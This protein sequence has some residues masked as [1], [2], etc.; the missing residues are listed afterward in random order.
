MIWSCT[1]CL[2]HLHFCL[3]FSLPGN[4]TSD[5][6]EPTP[7]IIEWIPDILPKSRIGELRIKLEYGHQRN[8]QIEHRMW[9][10]QELPIQAIT[11]QEISWEGRGPGGP[12]LDT[13]RHVGDCFSPLKDSFS[14]FVCL[15]D[16]LCGCVCVCVC[17]HACQ[18][19]QQIGARCIGLVPS[20]QPFNMF[21]YLS[22]PV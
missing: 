22:V 21:T 6:K 2:S 10:T 5:Q 13:P 4:T 7:F 11:V 18:H 20:C 9:P 16:R 19:Q 1:V 8:G 15:V 14:I 17:M 3:T 12:D